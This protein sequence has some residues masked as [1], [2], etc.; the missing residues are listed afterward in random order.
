MSAENIS[1]TTPSLSAKPVALALP[2]PMSLVIPTIVAIVYWGVVNFAIYG[3][4]DQFGRFITRCLATLALLIFSLAWWLASRHFSWRDRLVVLGTT[5]VVLTVTLLVADPTINLIGVL[6]SGMPLLISI[7]IAWLWITGSWQSRRSN[8]ALERN[9]LLIAVVLVLGAMDFVR[10]DGVWGRQESAYALRWTP[11]SEQKFISQYEKP[12]A[13]AVASAKA[14][15]AQPGDWLAF[16]GGERESVVTGVKLGDWEKNPPKLVWR[17]P[18]GPAWSSMI[19]VDGHLVTQEQRGEAEVVACYN[20]TTGEEE[21]AHEDALRFF[22]ALSGA[23][24]RSTPTFAEGKL[25][26]YGARGKLN[27]LD[28]ATGEAVW[29]K[30]VFQETDAAVPQWGNSVS[31]LVVDGLV[32]VWAGG[33]NDRGLVAYRADSGELAW[34]APAGPVTYATPQIMTLDDQ[35]QIVMHDNVSLYGVSLKDGKR[36]WELKN[37]SEISQPMLQPHL[38]RR[39]AEK[40]SYVALVGWGSGVAELPIEQGDKE[41]RLTDPAWTTEKLKPSFND[42]VIHEGHLYG[43]DDGILCCVDA[44]SGQRVWKKGRY[45][46]GQLLLLPDINELLVLTEKGEVVRVAAKP[47]KHEEHGRF[48]AIEGKTWNHPIIAHG[49]L[50]VR[51]SEE[52]ACYDLT[53]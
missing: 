15:E 45:G 3:D 19:V 27:C 9:G 21:W 28:P 44:S 38:L 32:V 31:P 1:A 20:A 47:Q 2:P 4:L 26:T 13:P 23:G 34:S 51:N 25:Y 29:S 24:P 37:P 14:W 40:E 22:E 17:R 41:W 52:M 43:L 36:L 8:P 6:L 50:Y 16:R 49:K 5:I 33:K 12:K 39:E 35:R 46:F 53:P 10:W 18:L 48:Q 30:D 42:F 7:G 11:T